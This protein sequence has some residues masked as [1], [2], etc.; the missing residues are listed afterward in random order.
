MIISGMSLPAY[1]MSHYILDIA[2]QA[3]PSIC[4][5]FGIHLFNLDVRLY[6]LNYG[7]LVPLWLGDN[8]DLHLCEPDFHLRLLVSLQVR[9]LSLDH[10]PP[11]LPGHRRYPPGHHPVPPPLPLD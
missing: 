3:I 11:L 4:A 2:F 1:W 7:V 6:C 8:P 5:I 9:R 10:N